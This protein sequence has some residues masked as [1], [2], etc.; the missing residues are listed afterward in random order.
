MFIQGQSCRRGPPRPEIR[1]SVRL[2]LIDFRS[3]Q[4]DLF[5]YYISIYILYIYIC[6]YTYIYVL[7]VILWN[8]E[9]SETVATCPTAT[10]FELQAEQ[11]E[12]TH[13]SS[14]ASQ[15]R[16]YVMLC[17][18]HQMVLVCGEDTIK[19]FP[20]V[21]WDTAWKI[22]VGSPHPGRSIL[23]FV[24]TSCPFWILLGSTFGSIVCSLAHRV[25]ELSR[26]V[27]TQDLT[28]PTGDCESLW[29]TGNQTTRMTF[30]SSLPWCKIHSCAGSVEQ[31]T[32]S[33]NFL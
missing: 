7:Q 12:P 32:I 26:F 24:H 22:I 16:D 23:W 10:P 6:M 2:N 11:L 19:V 20:Q 27:Q 29:F 31:E 28:V 1:P 3:I 13:R 15:V 21:T 9:M 33:G 8:V 17:C 18:P 30:S 4:E 5:S 25:V 14:Q